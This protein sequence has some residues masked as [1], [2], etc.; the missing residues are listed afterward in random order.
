MKT[1]N[2]LIALN[3]LIFV[4]MLKTDQGGLSHFQSGTIIDFGGLVGPYVAEG[5]YFRLVTAM[6]MHLNLLHLAMN[7]V[8]LHQVGSLLEPHYGS[9]RFLL[10]YLLAGIGGWAL[11][12]PLHWTHP[13]VSAGASGAISGLIGAGAMSGHL[14]GGSQ[15]R[16]VRDAMLRW[17]FILLVFGFF[18]GADNAAHGG[19]LVVGAG[20]AWLY[21]RKAKFMLRRATASAGLESILLILLVGGSFAWAAKDRKRAESGRLGNQAA[22]LAQRTMRPVSRLAR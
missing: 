8:S 7:M 5:Q 1:T 10:L 15:G 9:W 17:A 14:I 12:I 3:V 11:S 22:P 13:T 6:F 20:M 19:G 21:D 4:A 18:V 2:V 16:M